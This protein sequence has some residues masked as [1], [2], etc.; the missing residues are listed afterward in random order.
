[1]AWES[2]LPDYLWGIETCSFRRSWRLVFG[3]PDYLWGIETIVQ[4]FLALITAASRLPMR[5]WNRKPASRTATT[6]PLPDYLWGIETRHKL[7]QSLGALASR[8]PMRNWNFRTLRAVQAQWLSSFQTT[9]EELK[10]ISG[11]S[12]AGTSSASRLPMR[13]WNG[14]DGICFNLLQ[15]ASRLP[16]RNWNQFTITSELHS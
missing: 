2:E 16:M 15:I 11:I 3:L 8:L 4:G 7:E 14:F 9:Y 6:W 5:N 10:L 1:M 12:V 13:N